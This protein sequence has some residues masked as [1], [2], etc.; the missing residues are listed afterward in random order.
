MFQRQG[1]MDQQP[2]GVP[3]VEDLATKLMNND[4]ACELAAESFSIRITV[5]RW[6]PRPLPRHEKLILDQ[7]TSTW[8]TPVAADKAPYFVALVASSWRIRATLVMALSLINR[9][10]PVMLIC[11]GLP[12]FSEE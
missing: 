2:G 10:H 6:P 8:T 7:S 12:E 3:F 1:Q 5:D 11:S 4:L 9:S